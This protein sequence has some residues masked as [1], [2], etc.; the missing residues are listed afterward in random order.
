MCYYVLTLQSYARTD[1]I[2]KY[3]EPVFKLVLGRGSIY[4]WVVTFRSLNCPKKFW[5]IIDVLD[6][7]VDS[8]E[9]GLV[10]GLAS[11]LKVAGIVT[12]VVVLLVAVALIVELDFVDAV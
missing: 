11:L 4:I 7:V 5:E 1:T 6:D 12:A 8:A 10:I 2:N 3:N 9:A